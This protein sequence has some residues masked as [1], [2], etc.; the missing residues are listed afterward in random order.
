M[1]LGRE[2]GSLSVEMAISSIAL[3]AILFGICQV[4][5]GLYDYHFV[6]DAARQAT[7]YAMV[8]G[9]ASCTNTPNLSN[10][11][12]TADEIQTYVRDLN[13]PG[14]V[15]SSITVTTTW[16][17]ATNTTP[18]TWSACSSGT[19]NA[20]GNMVKVVVSYPVQYTIPFANTL[21]LNLGGASQ[22]VIAQ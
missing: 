6:A 17:T 10:C 7:R 18:R 1:Q 5:L 15:S 11:N 22:V 2:S 12:A 21:S 14:I 4:S 19:C 20:P 13:Y 8:R 16:Y 3:L 9:S